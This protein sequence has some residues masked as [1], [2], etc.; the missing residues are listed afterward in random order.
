MVGALCGVGDRPRV[1]GGA[2]PIMAG[3]GCPKEYLVEYSGACYAQWEVGGSRRLGLR[4]L[5]EG[6][7]VLTK[8]Y[9]GAV[10]RAL[11]VD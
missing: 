4:L 6:P 5:T 8:V 9:V 2:D 1:R 10:F 11:T 7:A 3:G